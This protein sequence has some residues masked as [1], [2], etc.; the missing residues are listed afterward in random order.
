MKRGEEEA[1]ADLAARVFNQFVAPGY[2]D[3]GVQEF[4]RY[5]AADQL[6]QRSEAG[7]FVLVAEEDEK[8]VGFIEMRHCEHVAMLFV[9]RQGRGVGKELMRQAVA[10]CRRTIPR[11]ARLTVHA[12]PG[13]VEVYGRMGFR[14]E[15]PERVE[16]GIRFV[17]MVLELD[18]E[19][20]GSW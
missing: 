3:E 5:A 8:L 10:R 9:A 16:N 18:Q 13:A 17:P 11:L 15:G 7:H 20:D 14:A 6:L 12:A 19:T 1:V 2:S 4:L